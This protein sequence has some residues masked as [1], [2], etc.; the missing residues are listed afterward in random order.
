MFIG[1]YGVSLAAKR[2]GLTARHLR[3]IALDIGAC[4]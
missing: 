4:R 1:H 2:V 3:A